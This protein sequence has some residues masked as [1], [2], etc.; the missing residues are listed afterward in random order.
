MAN[1]HWQDT[2][3]TV[4]GS[5]PLDRV[6]GS[7]GSLRI[8]RTGFCDPYTGVLKMAADLLG[9]YRLVGVGPKRRIILIPPMRHPLFTWCRVTDLQ[10]D[11]F[12]K[13]Q[14]TSATKVY[15]VAGLKRIALPRKGNFGAEGKA[16]VQITYQLPTLPENAIDDNGQGQNADQ[17][18]AIASESW[19]FS[20]R[21]L[22][23]PGRYY[24]WKFSG[25]ITPAQINDNLVKKEFADV[26][27]QLVR[28]RCLKIPFNCISALMG[29]VNY[30]Q[31]SIL[32]TTFPSETLLFL[33]MAATR[34][35]TTAQGFPFYELTYRFKIKPT[36]DK[37]VIS[38]VPSPGG[39]GTMYGTSDPDF[40]GWNRVYNFAASAWERQREAGSNPERYIY[41]FDTDKAS[42][43]IKN[44]ATV[45]GFRCLFD[46]RAN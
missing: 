15:D 1:Y 19:D 12:E 8:A 43:L 31:I 5:Q 13:L 30:N 36:I 27:Y 21:S 34:N 9:G 3:Q 22:T 39:G 40:V 44:G 14:Y 29:T 24:E 35:L 38:A 23:I 33:G 18:I 4:S 6:G 25:P 32:N 11:P 20:G 41:P 26:S 7:P 45:V 2:E 17:N 10:I 46:P 16:K 37:I 42:F 28:H